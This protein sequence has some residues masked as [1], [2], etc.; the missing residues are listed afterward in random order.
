M[1]DSNLDSM[2]ERFT[3]RIL[4]NHVTAW[5]LETLKKRIRRWDD[6]CGEW[7]RLAAE[8]VAIGDAANAAG[9]ALTAG[10][11]YVRA[12]SMY[13]WASFYF[14]HDERQFRTALEAALT[15]Y[16]KAA[17]LV[18]PPMTLLEIPYEG[19]NL[20][21]YLRTPSGVER[22]P[23]AIFCPGGDSTKEELYDLGEHIVRRGIAFLA[24]DG[25]GQGLVSTR[26]KMRPDYEL[27][28]RAVIDRVS[29]RDDIDAARI[30]VGGISYG[31][32]FAC[33]AAA[34]D[35]RVRA[36]VSVS[37]WYSPAGLF[38]HMPP[39]GRIAIRQ[40]FGDDPAAVQDRI[41][42][43]GAAE[44]ITVPLLQVYGGRDRASPPEEARR[45]E[46]EVRGPVKTI[47]YEE[48]VHVCN[49]MQNRARPLIAD[50]LAEQLASAGRA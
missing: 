10:D 45:V 25:P 24:F 6:W 27:A 22:P 40:Y 35:E 47:I 34:F 19:V 30:A 20:P 15:C 8:H 12:A 11:A 50:W 36:A 37:A 43:Q 5:E 29:A 44:R 28:I 9:R 1:S 7:S 14:V 31:G 3:W 38:A 26:L 46:K 18:D 48:G 33:R 32:L 42:M 13:H 17:P 2:F 39:L 23:L 4:A 41:T 49:N 21:A 16:R